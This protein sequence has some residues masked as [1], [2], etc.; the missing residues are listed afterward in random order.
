MPVTA[1]R[2]KENLIGA[3]RCG[4]KLKVGQPNCAE[5]IRRLTAVR[6]ALGDEFPLMVDAN[7]QWDR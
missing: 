4:I 2:V 7:Q 5:D 6:E 3:V 1:G